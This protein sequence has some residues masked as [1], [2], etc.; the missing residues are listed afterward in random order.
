MCRCGL[1]FCPRPSWWRMASRLGS[2]VAPTEYLARATWLRGDGEADKTGATWCAVRLHRD[3][4]ASWTGDSLLGLRRDEEAP[5]GLGH[6]ELP[7]GGRGISRPV[8]AITQAASP[9]LPVSSSE[10]LPSRSSAHYHHRPLPHPLHPPVFSW[11]P[12]HCAYVPIYPA[13]LVTHH[14]CTV[15]SHLGLLVTTAQAE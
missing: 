1:R 15:T 3:S 2:R 12:L 10:S 6:T 11:I 7:A 13:Q 9:T 5:S 14:V 4:A 8:M